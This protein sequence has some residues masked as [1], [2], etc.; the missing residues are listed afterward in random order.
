[1][2]V[3]RNF[4]SAVVVW[5]MCSK[6]VLSSTKQPNRQMKS[7]T[8]AGLRLQRIFILLGQAILSETNGSGMGTK[9]TQGLAEE[10]GSGAHGEWLVRQGASIHAQQLGSEAEGDGVKEKEMEAERQKGNSSGEKVALLSK[11]R[12][13]ERRQPPREADR[14]AVAGVGPASNGGSGHLRIL[15]TWQRPKTQQIRS[16]ST[17]KAVETKA[18]KEDVSIKTVVARFK[19]VVGEV[20][21]D[22]LNNPL[23][24]N[25]PRSIESELGTLSGAQM[26]VELGPESEPEQLEDPM[27]YEA[28]AEQEHKHKAN[29]KSGRGSW[30]RQARTRSFSINPHEGDTSEVRGWSR[31]RRARELTEAGRVVT[32]RPKESDTMTICSTK[33][34]GS[35][36]LT[37]HEQ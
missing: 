5:V 4:V 35:A 33:V 23:G 7:H 20:G 31:K 29:S 26:N 16:N 12:V 27:Q 11:Q 36:G 34:V 6:S 18:L 32:K 9:K 14:E 1:M 8:V 2:N 19:A 28:Q 21:R 30:K 10:G 24:H 37:Y 13:G 25:P 15:L 3:C 17:I 22:S